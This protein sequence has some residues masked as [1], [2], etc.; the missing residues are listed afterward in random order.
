MQLR[1]KDRVCFV[2]QKLPAKD[3]EVLK[4]APKTEFDE[5][6]MMMMMIM[7]G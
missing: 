1:G 4:G 2:F 6:M 5:I 7:N 3:G